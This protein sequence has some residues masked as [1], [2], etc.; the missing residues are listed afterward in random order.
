MVKVESDKGDV[1]VE[2]FGHGAD[3]IADSVIVVK[4][5]F[6][7]LSKKSKIAGSIFK[8]VVEK[9]VFDNAKTSEEEEIEM[10]ADMATLMEQMTE[11]RL[12]DE[13]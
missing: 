10:Q 1:N 3:V 2:M 7:G 13:E 8:T 6:D 9:S 12:R 11:R 4:A 5:L